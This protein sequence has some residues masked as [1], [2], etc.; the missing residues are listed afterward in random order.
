MSAFPGSAVVTAPPRYE[1]HSDFSA[2]DGDRVDG[3][4]GESA[5]ELEAT[6]VPAVGQ[7]TVESADIWIRRAR[8]HRGWSQQRLIHTM[9][10]VAG[11]RGQRLPADASMKAMLSRWENGHHRPDRWYRLLLQTALGIAEPSR[12]VAGAGS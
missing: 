2:G 11:G 1:P 3:C 7:R 12:S 8:H 9:R 5:Y 6:S 4:N 10:Q